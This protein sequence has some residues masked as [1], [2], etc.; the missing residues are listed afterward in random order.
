MRII[1]TCVL[2]GGLS[3]VIC[4]GAAKGDT[5]ICVETVPIKGD[6]FTMGTPI[7]N[8]RG[9]HYHEDEAPLTVNTADFRIGKHP[10]TAVQMCV[11]LNSAEAKEHGRESLYNHR[12]LGNYAYSTIT[13][14]NDGRYVP[15]KNADQTP[16]NQVTWKGAALFSTW[17]SARTGKHYRLPTEA[18]WEFAARGKEGRSWPWGSAAPSAKHGPRYSLCELLNSQDL[19]DRIKNNEPTWTTTAVGAH[20]ANATPEG[21]HDMLA[22]IIGE[23][24]A[25]K[26]VAHPTAE[27]VTNAE[28]DLRDLASD[29]IVR[30]YF[31]RPWSRGFL[32][33]GEWPQHGGRA[34]TRVHVHPM[35]AVNHAARHGFRVVEEIDASPHSR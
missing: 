29:R 25:N 32:P 18:E 5:P 27:Q 16:A 14:T 10:V 8:E 13:L 31:H 15:R 26:Y 24:C 30:G 7:R 1:A 17:L 12:N 19:A 6:V 35:N 23:W 22:Y 4:S 34:W 20:P 33:L 3:A 21:V 2:V 11:F 9:P 28:M